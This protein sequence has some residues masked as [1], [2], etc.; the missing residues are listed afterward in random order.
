MTQ[1]AINRV[2]REL[3]RTRKLGAHARCRNCGWREPEALCRSGDDILCYEHLQ[4]RRGRTTIEAHHH[5]GEALDAATVLMPGNV[6]RVLNDRQLDWQKEI[7]MNPNNDPL[8]WLAA[9]VQGLHDHLAWWLAH[10]QSIV[11]FLLGLSE[12]LTE[13]IGPTW[14]VDLDAPSFEGGR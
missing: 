3:K 6:H 11:G 5:F 4:A 2:T 7:L 1:E 13:R 14:W 9:G 10:L 12:S 8:R